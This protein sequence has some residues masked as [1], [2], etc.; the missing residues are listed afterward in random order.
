LFI[1]GIILP[2]LPTGYSLFKV[3]KYQTR[4][5]K[6]QIISPLRGLPKVP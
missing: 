5:S 3:S 6:T 4:K 2:I 1:F